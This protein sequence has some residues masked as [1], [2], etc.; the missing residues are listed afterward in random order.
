M[1]KS[2]IFTIGKGILIGTLLFFIPPFLLL[3]FIPFMLLAMFFMGRMSRGNFHG[4]KLAFADKMRSMSEEDYQQFKTNGPQYHCR[5][6]WSKSN[7]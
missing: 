5:K 4:H 6:D 3:F 1:K 7:K 2:L